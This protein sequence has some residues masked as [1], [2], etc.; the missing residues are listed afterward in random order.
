M[1]IRNYQLMRDEKCIAV[2]YALVRVF[3]ANAR[4]FVSVFFMNRKTRKCGAI[5]YRVYAMLH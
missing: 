4:A 3:T 1:E 2:D 5:Y